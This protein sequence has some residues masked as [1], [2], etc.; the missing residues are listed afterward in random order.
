MQ[1][2]LFLNALF[3]SPQAWMKSW[4]S[5]FSSE[6][7]CTQNKT[8]CLW[9]S[10]TWP[11][12]WC[13]ALSKERK[14]PGILWSWRIRARVS[15]REL[16]SSLPWVTHLISAGV[17]CLFYWKGRGQNCFPNALLSHSH[18]PLWWIVRA[19]E[20]LTA[21][22][23]QVSSSGLGGLYPDGLDAGELALS[24]CVLACFQLTNSHVAGATE[25]HLLLYDLTLDRICH[26]QKA[27]ALACFHSAS[28]TRLYSRGG[29]SRTWVSNWAWLQAPHCKKVKNVSFPRG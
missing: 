9:T 8:P 5:C 10:K 27:G 25:W 2:Y 6:M 22:P 11:G 28:A 26:A 13:F 14:K 15:S 19:L 18:P 1:S 3:P 17:S 4:S 24:R 12:Q 20:L 16:P 29:N 23:S 21:C 7:S